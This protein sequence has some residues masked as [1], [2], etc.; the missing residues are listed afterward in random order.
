MLL[1]CMYGHS[2][3]VCACV[4]RCRSAQCT[5]E[6]SGGVALRMSYGLPNVALQPC[7]SH[8]WVLLIHSASLLHLAVLRDCARATH[9]SV[10]A[11]FSCLMLLLSQQS[12]SRCLLCQ[13]RKNGLSRAQACTSCYCLCLQAAYCV[14]S[15]RSVSVRLNRCCQCRS[16]CSA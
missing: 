1:A 13:P 6:T 4:R 10:C 12:Y 7:F 3:C 8:F 14:C 5:V 2:A 11:R 9:S 15:N 16:C